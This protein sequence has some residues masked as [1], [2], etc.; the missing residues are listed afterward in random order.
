MNDELVLTPQLRW[1]E[2]LA[3]EC[4][5]SIQPT[6]W[7]DPAAVR[8]EG[9]RIHVEHGAISIVAHD[10]AGAFYARQTLH[11]FRRQFP[12]SL[13][14]MRIEDWPDFPNRAF[15]LD[16]SRDKVPTMQTLFEL[17]DLVSQ[18]KINQLQLY[19]EHTFAYARHSEVWKVASPMTANEI[20]QIDE[21]CR[22]RFIEL[23]ANQN[24]FGHMERWLKH[25]RYKPLAECPDGFDFPW[26][27][28][29]EMGFSLNPLDPRSLE[30]IEGLYDEL[31]PNFTSRQFNVG[32]DETFDLGLGRS[33]G[34]CERRGRER[35]YL[36]F[37]LKIHDLVSRRGRTMQFW[38]DI[39]LHRPELI[40]DL[41]RDVIAL[42]WGY[43][44]DHPFEKETRA[45]AHAGLPFYVCPGTSSWCSISGRTDNAIANLR[46]AAENGLRCGAI[47]YLI[48]DWGDWGHLQYLPVSYLGIAY[49]AALAWCCEANLD[50]SIHRALDLHVFHDAAGVMGKLAYDFGNVYHAFRQPIG[51]STRLFWALVGGEERRKLYET[52]TR[53]EYDDA[54][55]RID[56]AVA[57]LGRARMARADASLTQDEFRS[58]A[59]MLRHAC[60]RGRGSSAP[61]SSI[62]A[63]VQEHRRLWLARNRPGGLQDSCRRLLSGEYEQ[64]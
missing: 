48:T 62:D 29:H 64:H 22:D 7:I 34:E 35:V 42:N 26:G 20:R 57:N 49:G 30:L 2:R 14:C 9:Y 46:S 16:I 56:S 33:K 52:V 24:S 39:I 18:L 51:N 36:E 43:D 61:T 63:I 6:E 25:S 5:T 45:F 50:L 40:R 41:P 23:V 21:Y 44:A 3:G 58:A 47:G 8:G 55:Q 37:L 28:R 13:P 54:E 4:P 53:E 12:Q 60:Q 15:L 27:L 59:A 32:C 38:G 11:Q 31:L 1:V 19:T 10:P 17:V